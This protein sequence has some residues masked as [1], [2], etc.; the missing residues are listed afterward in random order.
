MQ[1]VSLLIASILQRF[2]EK[3]GGC[4]VGSLLLYHCY[5][6]TPVL[7]SWCDS[8]FHSRHNYSRSE[9]L[10]TTFLNLQKLHLLRSE[11][12]Y[13]CIQEANWNVYGIGY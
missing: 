3:Q 11:N 1:Y 2:N 9:T 6:A 12:S 10:L 5:D 7:Q 13:Y 8:S 4:T